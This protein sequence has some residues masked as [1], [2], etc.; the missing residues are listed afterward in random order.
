MSSFIVE[1][2]TINR[3]VSFCFWEHDSIL[4][5]EIRRNLKEVNIDLEQSFKDDAELDKYLKCFGEELL[6]LNLLA[7][8]DR[9]KHIKDI[10]KEIKEAIKE[11]EFEDLPLKDRSI[12]QVLKSIQCLL[13][14][15]SEGNIPE[16]PLFKVLEKITEHLKS[17][18]INEIPEYNQAVWG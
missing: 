12:L 7:F 18:I 15:C 3:I 17:H 8:Y 6:K 11:Y 14:Q 5:Y 4:K 13:Y 9:Y 2:K 16:Q 10:Q 1:N